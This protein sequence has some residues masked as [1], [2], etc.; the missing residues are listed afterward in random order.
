MNHKVKD[1]ER[2]LSQKGAKDYASHGEINDDAGDIDCGGD[3][4]AGSHGGIDPNAA[5]KER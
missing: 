4:R 1:P 5:E 2:G 3:K